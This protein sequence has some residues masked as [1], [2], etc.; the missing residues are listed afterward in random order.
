M[1]A[2]AGAG[3]A[4]G[5]AVEISVSGW[6]F[7]FTTAAGWVLA[8]AALITLCTVLRRVL[9]G[10]SARYDGRAQRPPQPD[11]A[12]AGQPLLQS[13]FA[14]QLRVWCFAGAGSGAAPLWRPGQRPAV[15]LRLSLAVLNEAPADPAQ[16]ACLANAL[17]N[18]LALDLD[19]SYQLQAAGGRWARL[20]LRLRVKCANA[21]WWR[22]RLPTDPW[23]AGYLL[24]QPSAPA[25]WSQWLPRRASLLVADGLALPLL[26]ACLQSLAANQAAFDHPVRLLIV[27]ARDAN[28]EP[29][30]VATAVGTLP[31]T[32]FFASS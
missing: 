9:P 19:G 17:A 4:G 22:Q 12:A 28:A 7:G 2:P 3:G 16:G 29:L 23:D 25:D 13:A 15:D 26:Q 1:N 24:G 5:A 30:P 6:G 11:P 27:Q 14:Q 31:M 21:C 8:G 32:R 18:A 20:W 10:L